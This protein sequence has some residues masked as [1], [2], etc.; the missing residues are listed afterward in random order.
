VLQRDV[1]LGA[2]IVPLRITTDPAAPP[3]ARAAFVR[4]CG[5]PFPPD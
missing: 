3:S 4:W 2:P 1:V 5:Q